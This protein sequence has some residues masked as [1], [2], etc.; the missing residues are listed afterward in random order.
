MDRWSSYHYQLREIFSAT[1]TSVLEIGVGDRVVGNVLKAHDIAYTSADIADD[2]LPDVVADVTALPFNEGSFDVVCAFE[3]LEHLPF[4]KFDLALTELA[5]VSRRK[6]LLSLPHF[7][8]SIRCELKVPFLPQ[9]RFAWKAPFPKAHVFNGQHYWELGKRG[10]P[11]R[12]IRDILSTH[13]SI[14]KEFVPFENQYHHF[15]VLR[16]KSISI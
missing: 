12:R 15:F 7:G 4:E 9:V 16:K 2:L 13:F 3:V 6:V 14:E 8:P 10:F 11:P 5:R 1:P